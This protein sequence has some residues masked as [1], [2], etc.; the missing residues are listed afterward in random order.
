[1]S[2]LPTD[3]VSLVLSTLVLGGLSAFGF[4]VRRAFSDLT[5]GMKELRIEALASSA[6][7]VAKIDTLAASLHSNNT[8][9]AVLRAR[10]DRLES[11]LDRVRAEFREIKEG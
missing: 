3:T 10:V 1:M 8:E 2:P 9:V 6:A 4:L 7:T 5:E 11:E